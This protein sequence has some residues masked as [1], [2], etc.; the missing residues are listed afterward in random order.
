[1]DR[2][3][4][5]FT[6]KPYHVLVFEKLKNNKETLTTYIYSSTVLKGDFKL[7]VFYLQVFPF[8][9]TLYFY[10][11]TFQK[12]NII[13]TLHYIYVTARIATHISD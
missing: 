2:F 8:Y 3:A 7:L 13:L 1:M 12:G 4:H 5:L 11:T 10:S 6:Q 9:T